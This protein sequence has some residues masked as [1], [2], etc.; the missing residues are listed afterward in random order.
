MA[1]TS[2]SAVEV[3]DMLDGDDSD[4]PESE[5]SEEEGYDIFSY[6]GPSLMTLN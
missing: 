1:S 5:S 6:S 4:F 3:L 2:Y